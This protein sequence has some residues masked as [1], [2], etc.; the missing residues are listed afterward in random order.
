MPGAAYSWT[1]PNGFTSS[2]QNPS[3]PNATT[4]ASGIYS[5]TVLLNGCTSA[6]G[7]TTATVNATPAAP[8]ASNNGPINA[9]ATLNLTSSTVPGATYNWTGPNSFTSTEQNPSIVNATTNASGLYSVTATTG[10]CASG[11][12]MMTV[13]VNPLA[14]VTIQFLDG[15]AILSW[16]CG[17]LQSATN[18]SGPW[19]D[20]SGATCPRTN[21]AAALQEFYRLRLQ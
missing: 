10:S 4:S 14:R 16:L 20:V 3:I 18:I 5:V 12:G 21:P 6:A 15:K 13:I 9:G 2:A 11:P 8:T 19:C 17:T 1:G 7:A